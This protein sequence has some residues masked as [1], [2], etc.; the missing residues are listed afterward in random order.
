MDMD[1]AVSGGLEATEFVVSR[2]SESTGGRA[3]AERAESRVSQ[4]SQ[5]ADSGLETE[6]E[7]DV[8]SMSADTVSSAETEYQVHVRPESVPEVSLPTTAASTT[9]PPR[10]ATEKATPAWMD[11]GSWLELAVDQEDELG[12]HHGSGNAG[13]QAQD[14]DEGVTEVENPA[15]RSTALPS[16]AAAAAMAPKDCR[17]ESSMMMSSGK[18]GSQEISVLLGATGIPASKCPVVPTKML[19]SIMTALY[20]PLVKLEV[21]VLTRAMESPMQ[22]RPRE[23]IGKGTLALYILPDDSLSLTFEGPLDSLLGAS[24]GIGCDNGDLTE[25]KAMDMMDIV[26]MNLGMTSV[27]DPE[28]E[29]VEG[30]VWEELAR[31]PRWREQNDAAIVTIHMLK[32][33]KTG[34][35]FYVLAG[36]EA[37]P[38]QFSLSSDGQKKFDE[39]GSREAI[40]DE[41]RSQYT[42][43]SNG[44]NGMR[45]S[46]GGS[47]N[48]C[49]AVPDAPANRRHYFWMMGSNIEESIQ[50]LG[51]IKSHIK[52]PPTLAK[53]AGVSESV[54]DTVKEWVAHVEETHRERAE[55]EG[56]GE[57]PVGINPLTS[58]G[59]V[60]ARR[61]P[62]MGVNQSMTVPNKPTDATAGARETTLKVESDV[63]VT[64]NA[65]AIFKDSRFNISCPC[66]LSVALSTKSSIRLEST[67][68]S[69]GLDA[70]TCASSNASGISPFSLQESFTTEIRDPRTIEQRHEQLLR[71]AALVAT[72]QARCSSEVLARRAVEVIGKVRIEEWIC[73][74]F[75][76]S[77]RKNRLR[78]KA[79]R[80][81]KKELERGY[82]ALRAA[83]P[84]IQRAVAKLSDE[85]GSGRGSNEGNGGGRGVDT[86]R[87]DTDNVICM[88]RSR[89]DTS[90]SPESTGI[91]VSNGLDTAQGRRGEKININDLANLF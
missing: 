1:R 89:S 88:G 56:V 54:L 74:D 46:N 27:H 41:C 70:G 59:A 63:F 39:F 85:Y 86:P 42:N 37:S 50:A 18:H 73:E 65:N 22:L 52:R 20:E 79:E 35:S 23:H 30:S 67:E 2:P 9:T 8:C 78:A 81:R 55:R 24:S 75:V 45:L 40:G 31:F 3:L 36:D 44:S 19:S 43:A 69:T 15:E 48:N 62:Q 13:M 10:T 6:E 28:A 26:N 12:E 76:R 82:A 61:M 5:R 38:P 16:T 11:F 77:T 29:H 68:S 64:A 58:L 33:D 51:K 49:I 90:D 83:K 21:G 80:Q 53:I 34:R 57:V 4:V 47:V 91:D 25:Q 84:M 72:A 14:G 60:L 17:M 71:A 7:C 66:C 87:V 32:G